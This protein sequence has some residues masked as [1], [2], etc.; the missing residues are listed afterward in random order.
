M[1]RMV[2]AMAVGV[3]LLALPLQGAPAQQRSLDE[4]LSFINETL[5]ANPYNDHDG[6]LTVSRVELKRGGR[7]SFEVAKKEASSTVSNVF[8]AEI[9]DID[10]TSIVS[11]S[12]GDHMVIVI[13]ALGPVSA[14]L[15]CVTG[16]SVTQWDLPARS[17]MQL[18]FRT[19][20]LVAGE[21]TE[22]LRTLVTL[23]RQDA[24]YN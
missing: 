11:R 17:D 13:H 8:E 22:A 19:D 20:G 7:L 4:T 1:R 3:S 5:E 21:L 6:K 15:K 9:A 10:V 24:R 14:Q 16:G 2:G 23:A 18:E 12:G